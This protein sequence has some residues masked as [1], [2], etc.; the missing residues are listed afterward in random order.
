M[1]LKKNPQLF[2]PLLG[3]ILLFAS[4]RMVAVMLGTVLAVVVARDVGQLVNSK[5]TAPYS[6][7][8]AYALAI[9]T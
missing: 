6:A 2:P 8:R 7:Q 3:P 4:G 9:T 5:C 1:R